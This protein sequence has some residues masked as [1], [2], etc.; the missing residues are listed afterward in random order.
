MKISEI[1]SQYLHS[2]DSKQ[3]LDQLN[4]WT[5]DAERNIEIINQLDT[6]WVATEEMDDYQDF[7]TDSAWNK[8]Q[9]K[10]RETHSSK[11][12]QRSW[13][14]VAACTILAAGL[15]YWM[16]ALNGKDSTMS[17]MQKF[18]TDDT[19][20]RTVKL[21]DESQIWLNS[22]SSLAQI[23]DFT[24]DRSVKLNGQAYF[25]IHRDTQRPFIITTQNET[26][27]VLGTAFDLNTY[28]GAFD[29]KVTEGLVAV[30]TS[31]RIIEVSAN[32]NLVKNNGNYVLLNRFDENT[33]KWRFDNLSFD[34]TP[35]GDVLNTLSQT[36]QV[37]F[38]NVDKVDLNNCL[39]N[40]KFGE[41]S[42]SDILDELSIITQLKV[43]KTD[44]NRYQIVSVNCN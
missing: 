1:I 11:S 23:S 38:D 8:V 35:L 27:T 41:E 2:K 15:A 22:S 30:N 16:I 19:E 9:Q 40:T 33:L 36:Y 42:L 4:N 21:N 31:K 10:N 44:T 43:S 39:I 26:V 28:D 37:T 12:P 5:D 3:E 7:D 14:M 17:D 20:L 24:T 18:A 32:Q 25:D 6:V 34:N 13:L 29:L